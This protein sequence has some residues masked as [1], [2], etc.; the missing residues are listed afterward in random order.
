VD[1][2]RCGAFDLNFIIIFILTHKNIHVESNYIDTKTCVKLTIRP[3]VT[4]MITQK[5]L[6]IYLFILFIFNPR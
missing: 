1:S 5:F 6:F 2:R 3:Q 4:L